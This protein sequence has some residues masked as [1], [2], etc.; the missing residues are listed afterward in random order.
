MTFTVQANLVVG[1]NGATTLVGRSHGLSSGAD[2]ARF[3]E[4][5]AWADCILIGGESY[6][7]EPY[8]KT[9]VPL[10]VCSHALAGINPAT[11]LPL[12]PVD[13][14]QEISHRGFTK[15]LIEG[16][17]HLLGEL[18]QA[19]LVDGL[20]ITHTNIA[21]DGGFVDIEELTA[22]LKLTKSEKIGAESFLY[23][24]KK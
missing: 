18:L 14:L 3:H 19:G 17:A 20:Y 7:S 2:R 22:N 13:S 21:G 15:V 8:Q 11:V 5:R 6:R 1:S 4:I 9:P 23:F 10:F 16:G 12:S 24:T